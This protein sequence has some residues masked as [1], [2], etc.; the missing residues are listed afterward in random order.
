MDGRFFIALDDGPL[1]ADPTWTRFDDTD[2]L[3]AGLDISSGRQTLMSLTGTGT[4]TAY[5][6]DQSGRF[7][8]RNT[9]SD[10]FGK[11]DGKQTM[12]QL[13]NP[14]TGVWEPQFR[15]WIDDY[16]YD[17]D[18]SA[19]DADGNPINASIQID[20]VDVFDYLAGYGLTPGLDG[21]TP[22]SGSEDTIYYAETSGTL[23][24]R[25]IEVLT[26]VGI[27]S[28]RYIVFSG[29]VTLMA[30]KYDPD[31]AALT[32]LRDCADADL[33]FI[34]NIYVDRQGRFNFHGRYS[35]F[36][37][38][39]ISAAYPDSGWDFQ[40]W[41]VGDGKA[42]AADSSRAQMRVLSFSRARSNIINAAIAYPQGIAAADMPGQAYVDSTSIT[43][44]GKH[45]AQPMS[46]LLT[47]HDNVLGLDGNATTALFAEL[48]VK[49]QKDPREAL[50]ALQVRA[51]RP[52]DSRA[53][54]TWALLTQAD[55]SDIVN[56]AVGYPG[57][58]G[59]TG[60][61]PD[62]DYYIEG[63]QMRIRPLNP[64]HDYV[65]LDLNVSPAVWSM[66]T[67]GVMGT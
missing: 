20:C 58:T 52:D 30:V 43:D 50:T 45:A 66:D 49:N 65:E 17:I 11:L 1:V 7:D 36:E 21:V 55:I 32:V 12:F 46:D 62:D 28:T 27:D 16:G 63:R 25:I 13:Y 34:A 8:P 5:L 6:N 44:Y 37:P 15:G 64:D 10:L 59:F 3:V 67:H 42:I 51:I 18:G 54:E 60:S 61:S 14:V 19:V 2:G 47:L 53:N 38:D 33:P 35:R 22:P 26:D 9:S 57:G 4:G 39:V 23:D 41:A 48:M 40:R 24:D 31:E 56:V 29:N